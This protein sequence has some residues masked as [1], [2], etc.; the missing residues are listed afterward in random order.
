MFARCALT[1]A[2][3][4]LRKLRRDTVVLIPAEVQ[5][6][7]R[8]MQGVRRPIEALDFINPEGRLKDQCCKECTRSETQIT[9][10]YL[11]I[12]HKECE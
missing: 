1:R 7:H 3:F 4:Y 8:A 5:V 2:E 6:K 10:G 9:R 11:K 12:C